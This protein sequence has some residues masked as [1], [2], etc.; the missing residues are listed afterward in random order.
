MY[1]SCQCTYYTNRMANETPNHFNIH[2]LLEVQGFYPLLP[3]S[4]SYF[5]L[6]NKMLIAF[7]RY[8]VLWGFAIDCTEVS[9]AA[10]PAEIFN[11]Q[12]SKTVR[13]CPGCSTWKVFRILQ[14]EQTERLC[15][16]QQCEEVGGWHIFL[17]KAQPIAFV[18][19]PSNR[20]LKNL[21]ITW[22]KHLFDCF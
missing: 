12:I 5:M 19:P 20:S 9:L 10:E 2:M 11:K 13:F 18:F 7:P 1:P 15:A 4:N 21:S 3:F 22:G 17:F 8:T 6:T 14:E 16:L